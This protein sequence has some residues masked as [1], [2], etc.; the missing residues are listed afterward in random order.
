VDE[1]VCDHNQGELSLKRRGEKPGV[2][3]KG[4]VAPKW[5]NLTAGPFVG[6]IDLWTKW[7]SEVLELRSGWTLPIE[8]IRWLRKFDT[9]Q[10]AK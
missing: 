3:V 5:G 2:E 9:A 8:K 1:Y 4:L 6:P 10:R 7:T